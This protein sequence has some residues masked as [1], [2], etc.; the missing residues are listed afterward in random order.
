MVLLGS[1][2][3]SN[4][5]EWGSP[6]FA[7]P[8]S[9]ANGVRFLSDFKNLKNQL[10]Y[11]PHPMTNIYEILLKVKDF[12]NYSPLYLNTGYNYI[13]LIED[14]SNLCTVIISQGKHH[15]KCLPMGVSNNLKILQQRMNDLFQGFEFISA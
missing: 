8:K 13:R 2:K 4:D 14:T 7:Q 3:E 9:K 11:K 12:Q 15:C 6:Y 10:K 1:L 5:S